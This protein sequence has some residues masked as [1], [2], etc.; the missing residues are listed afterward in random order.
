VASR[1]ELTA[2]LFSDIYEPRLDAP[3]AEVVHAYF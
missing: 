1:G 3:D 2:R